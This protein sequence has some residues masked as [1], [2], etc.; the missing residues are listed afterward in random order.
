LVCCNDLRYD[1]E[2][3][4]TAEE[5]SPYPEVR[6][7]VANA[8]DPNMPVSTIRSWTIGMTCAIITGVSPCRSSRNKGQRRWWRSLGSQRVSVL[9]IS[10]N[11]CAGGE[12]FSNYIMKRCSCSQIISMLIA[13]PAGRAWAAWAPRWS[14]LGLPLNPGPFSIKEHVCRVETTFLAEVSS[15][16]DIG[17][18]LYHGLP[19]WHCIRDECYRGPENLLPTKL[20]IWM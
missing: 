11:S 3:H 2:A 19:R 13:F 15:K 1:M 20:R 14:I 12:A 4:D 5:D 7:A 9:P 17:S 8:D 10:F 6:S 18:H 16:V